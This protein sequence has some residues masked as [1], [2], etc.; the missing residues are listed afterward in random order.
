MATQARHGARLAEEQRK[1]ERSKSL[2]VMA[3]QHLSNLGYTG[4][5]EALQ[6][7]S[8]V[9]LAQFEVA[10]NVELLSVVQ[11]WEDYFEH[12]FGRR[13]KLTRKLTKLLSAQVL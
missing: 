3:L 5:V 8:G 12:R 9:T 1:Q 10:D 4:S 13:P 11:E 7:E 2:I 6:A